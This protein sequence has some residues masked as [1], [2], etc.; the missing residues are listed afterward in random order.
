MK[1]T[2][3]VSTRELEKLAVSVRQTVL[4]VAYEAHVGHIA[5]ALSI[6][7]I[8]VV[9]YHRVL[10]I[11]PD[12][13]TNPR[14][15]RFIL[16]KGHAALALYA[17][18][19]SRGFIPKSVLSGYCKDG[20]VLGTHPEYALRHGIELSTGSLGHGLSVGVG[21]ALGLRRLATKKD[22]PPR[23]FVLVSDSELDE[24]ST[25]E[26]IMF[27]FHHKLDNL[28]AIVDD[29]GLQAFGRT[30][31]VLNIQ[32]IA[33]KWR[34]FGWNVRIVEGNNV[35][36]L[37]RILSDIPASPGRPS[38]VV[39]KT[40]GGS[41]VPFMQDSFAWHYWPMN[42]SQYKEAMMAMKKK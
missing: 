33:Q 38:V 34:A 29:N 13:P 5:S 24:G 8:L 40:L 39:A 30:R 32:P 36:H 19:A 22:A 23:V 14:R 11:F 17:T 16:S 35:R 6:V 27:A 1:K 3:T 18:L 10:R 42:E 7:D 21:M 20:G 37:S 2:K 41:G 9:L 25:W 26:A 31:D 4:D 28:V 15:D 12:A